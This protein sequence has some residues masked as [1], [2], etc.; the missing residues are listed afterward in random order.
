MKAETLG[1]LAAS[2]GVVMAV[3]P[4][5]QIRTMIRHNAAE[6]VSLGYFALLLPGFTLWA[7][8]G[9]ARRDI[10]LV[11]PNVV[12]FVVAAATMA[13]AKVVRARTSGRRIDSWHAAGLHPGGRFH[14]LALPRES[15]RRR[16]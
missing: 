12:S 13:T 2:W 8:Y 11:V 3:A 5:L 14:R 7:A 16:R 1:V 4:A 15:G 6:Q 9:V 10:A